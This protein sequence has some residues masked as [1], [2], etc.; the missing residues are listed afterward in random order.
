M[1]L[2]NGWTLVALRDA[3]R[4]G[5]ESKINR[6]V[7][8]F[9]SVCVPAVERFARMLM[10]Q[11]LNRGRGTGK[12]EDDLAVDAVERVFD[13]LTGDG[14]DRVK[15]E[16]HLVRI[17]FR[18]TRFVWVDALRDGERH[19]TVMSGDDFAGKVAVTTGADNDLWAFDLPAFAAI[20]LLFSDGERF[21]RRMKKSKA[22]ERGVAQY[23]AL[24]LY[25]IGE[26]LYDDI[27]DAVPETHSIVRGYWRRL[28]VGEF[29][30]APA[31]WQAV[32]DAATVSDAQGVCET[33]LLRESLRRAVLAATGADIINRGKRHVLRYEMARFWAQTHRD[34]WEGV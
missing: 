9:Y 30:I 6:A 7:A 5:D 22:G 19:P 28:A 13:L 15:N 16:L 18:T 10:R 2:T 1:L 32:E 34:D 25:E 4:S 24:V 20:R 3:L 21:V 31:L 33:T 23:R 17:L 27:A 14:G 12:N 26:K 11:S 29:C 8:P